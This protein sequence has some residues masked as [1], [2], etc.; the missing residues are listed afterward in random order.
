M[1]TGD[2]T[3]QED[4]ALRRSELR[5]RIL[6]LMEEDPVLAQAHQRLAE[7]RARYEGLEEAMRVLEGGD[8]PAG[9]APARDDPTFGQRLADAFHTSFATWW[10]VIA[11]SVLIAIWMVIN[12]VGWTG[13]DNFPFL[14]LNLAFS[15]WAAYAAPLILMA[16]ARAAD[17]E[18]HRI[19]EQSHQMATIARALDALSQVQGSARTERQ[20]NGS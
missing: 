16:D 20:G 11:Q 8:P 13:F 6:E 10:F 2:R 3:V 1:A 15:L 4:L 18:R 14:F 12:A 7:A 5:S 19:E 9:A 17:R